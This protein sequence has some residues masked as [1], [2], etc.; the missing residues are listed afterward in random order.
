MALIRELHVYGDVKRV[1]QK[2]VDDKVQHIGFGKRLIYRAESIA[3]KNG[4]R[5]I[6]IISAVGTRDYY[7]PFDHP[8]MFD[9]YVQQNQMIWLPEDVPLHNDVKDWQEMDS[10][11]R[12][13]RKAALPRPLRGA[14]RRLEAG[15]R[16][17]PLRAGAQA[18]AARGAERDQSPH[19]DDWRQLG[20][21]EARRPRLPGQ[22]L[23]V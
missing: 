12:L 9:Y 17:G 10:T 16:A 14:V 6:A 21:L 2:V 1:N 3:W 20:P 11:D 18:R 4:Y 13:R 15:A 7:K 19:A 5:K 23:G 22:R 8:W